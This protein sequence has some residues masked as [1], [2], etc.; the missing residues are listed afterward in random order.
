MTELHAFTTTVV[1]D[2]DRP[3]RW[4]WSVLADAKVRDNSLWSFSSRVEA[5]ATPN[6]FVAKL[7]ITWQPNH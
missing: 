5:Q 1:P 3:G 7:N 6:R 2:I 4:R